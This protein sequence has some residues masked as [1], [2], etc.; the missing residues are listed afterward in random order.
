MQKFI[1]NTLRDLKVELTEEFDSNF[2][3]KAFFDQ[4]WK[5]TR[6]Q[7]NRGSLLMRSGDLRRSIRAKVEGQSIHFTS[8]LPYASIHNEGGTIVVTAKMKKFFWAMYYKSSGAMGKG[9]KNRNERLSIE[10]QQWKNLALM[11]VG[12]KMKIEQRQ[13]IGWHPRLEKRIISIIDSNFKEIDD[14]VKN[15]L[16][17]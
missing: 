7:N 8:A 13:F 3:R 16:K 11:K 6:L 2:T 12:Q 14:Y 5:Q 1:K 17:R 9:S 10:A 15:K 4:P